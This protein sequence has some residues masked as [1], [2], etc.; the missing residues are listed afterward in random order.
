MKNILINERKAIIPIFILS[1]LIFFFTINRCFTLVIDSIEYIGLVCRGDFLF[2]PHHLFYET[3]FFLWGDLLK[4]LGMPDMALNLALLNVILGSCSVVIIYLILKVRFGLSTFKSLASLGFPVFSFGFWI[5]STSVNVYAASLLLLLSC[6]YVYLE[7]NESRKKWVIIGI[8]H[9]L[10]IVFNQWNIFIFFVI[11]FS[12]VFSAS[13]QLVLKKYY[14][15]YLISF[16]AIVGIS[17]FSVMIFYYHI[18]SINGMYHWV[19]FYSGLFPW[20]T[21]GIRS[22][23]LAITGIGQTIISPFWFF[24]SPFLF[25]FIHSVLPNVSL[26]EEIYFSHKIN[27]LMINFLIVLSTITIAILFY[28]IIII[29]KRFKQV[30]QIHSKKIIFMINWI[31]ISSIMPYFW[32]SQNQRYWFIQT[33]V[34]FLMI[35]LISLNIK[36]KLIH[37]V[38]IVLLI[39]LGA[40]LF[41][42]NFTGSFS[43]GV[44]K[45]NDLIYHKVI[46]LDGKAKHGD[47]IIFKDIW[48]YGG[49]SSYYLPGTKY[50]SLSSLKREENVEKAF[51][52]LNNI[53]N[54]LIKNNIFISEDVFTAKSEYPEKIRTTINDIKERYKHSMRLLSFRY[55]KFYEINKDAKSNLK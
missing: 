46:C 5:V 31:I 21:F 29:F 49:Y 17:Y 48:N 8:F 24:N 23:K 25:S 35:I 3:S 7:D 42:V 4:S 13:R 55:I 43:I 11:T 15:Y 36:G 9:G 38:N 19:T 47:L 22:L 33:T 54:I 40:C 51:I 12:V 1:F 14:L 20:N 39:F 50:L 53:D 32:S 41:F 27:P 18:Y 6:F 34:F 52:L 10:A 16:S 37:R 45:R 44:D 28:F 26:E 2:F 30:F